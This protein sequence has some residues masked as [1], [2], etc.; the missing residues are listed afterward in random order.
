MS[1]IGKQPIAVPE[2]V[3]VEIKGNEVT[4]KGPKGEL[5]RSVHPDMT[6]AIK[7]KNIIVSRPS[8]RKDHKALHGL[9]R[10]LLSNMVHG[11]TKGYE[12]NLE[13]MGVGYRAQKAGDKIT[14][15]VG[16]SHPVEITPPPGIT[17]ALDG[18]TKIKVSGIDKEALGQFAADLRA[19]YPPD[20]Y[21]GKGIK[22]AD[23]KLRL[24]PGKAGKATTATKK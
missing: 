13:I 2:G 19:I 23:E 5:K 10:T 9:T 11:V 22:Y 24:K 20:S 16:F 15:Q 17:L 8:D 3:Q 12:R 4:V 21:K 14:L 7:D 18:Q 1:R 6:V